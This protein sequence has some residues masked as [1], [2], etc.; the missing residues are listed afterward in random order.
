MEL[1]SATL[2]WLTYIAH[3]TGPN[4][5]EIRL[6]E[7]V[8]LSAASM[9]LAILI[10]IPAG[11]YIGHTGRGTAIAINLA[12]FGRALPSLAVIAIVLPTTAAFDPQL[13]FKVYPTLIAMVL[14]AIPPVLVN[15]YAGVAG[16][17]RDL[18]EAAR[19]MGLRDGQILRRVEIPIALPVILGG[20]RSAAVQVVATATLG[21][22]FGFGGLGRLIVEGIAQNDDGMLFGGVALVALLA[23]ITEIVFGLLQRTFI[24]PGLKRAAEPRQ[25]YRTSAELNGR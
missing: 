18:V 24:S 22:L 14:L 16:V 6:V 1:I 8:G 21:A 20:V 17:D 19:G 3:W 12:N 11:F 13:G 23:I 25:A 4:G 10:A 15:A 5:I 9:L 2:A 7:H